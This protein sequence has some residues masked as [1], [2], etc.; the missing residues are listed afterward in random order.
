[1]LELLRNNACCLNNSPF[2]VS[3]S[4]R[5]EGPSTGSG[6]AKGSRITPQLYSRQESSKLLP[7]IFSCDLSEGFQNGTRNLIAV[8][9]MF[10][11][12]QTEG[13]YHESLDQNTITDNV[14][15]SG[16]FDYHKHL[17]SLLLSRKTR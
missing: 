9:G 15:P 17:S 13:K 5:P 6:R 12:S 4:N 11:K 16:A 1:M 3:V 14:Y 8:N 2:G 7:T 10:H